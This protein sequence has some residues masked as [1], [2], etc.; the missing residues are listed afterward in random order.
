MST[1]KEKTEY[2]N[3][4]S[5]LKNNR[6]VV[7]IM[8]A[9]IGYVSVSQF[10]KLTAE[11]RKN[12]LEIIKDENDIPEK[13]DSVKTAE[14]FTAEQPNNRQGEQRKESS[15]ILPFRNQHSF[16]LVLNSEQINTKK[17]IDGKA[18][19]IISG[20][21]TVYQKVMI[22]QLNKT[23]SLELVGKDY[24]CKEQIFISSNLQNIYPCD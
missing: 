4:I 14:N 9:F 24:N 17:F 6:F 21:N 11:N 22:N 3:V 8:I 5:R 13:K 15:K 7:I 23:Y 18:A 19:Q 2:D 20:Q 16:V 10:L 1:E 12:F